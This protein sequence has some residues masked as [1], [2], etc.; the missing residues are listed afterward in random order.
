MVVASNDITLTLPTV[1]SAN[2]GLQITI[3]N[4]GIHTDLIVIKGNG[5]A[6]IDN[7]DSVS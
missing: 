6:T 1:T 3:K 4:I 5:A 2:D 7:K